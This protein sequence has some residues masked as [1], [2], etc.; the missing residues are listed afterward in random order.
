MDYNYKKLTL[1]QMK[2]YIE[3]NAPQDKRW[4]KEVAFEERTEKKAVKLY[5]NDGKPVMKQGKNGKMYHALKMEDVKGGKKKMV[6]NLLKAKKAFCMR[7]MPEIMPK[8]EEKKSDADYI[9]ENW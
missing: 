6:F 3:K 7:Y 5:D 2:E 4:F 9:F 1:E 8:R